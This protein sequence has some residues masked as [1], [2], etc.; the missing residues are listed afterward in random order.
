MTVGTISWLRADAEKAKRTARRAVIA[1]AWWELHKPDWAPALPVSGDEIWKLQEDDLLRIVFVGDYASSLC[2]ADWDF[3]IHP[4]FHD[5]CCNAVAWRPDFL[6]LVRELKL[7][8]K[9]LPGFNPR[10]KCWEPPETAAGRVDTLRRG[11][12]RKESGNASGKPCPHAM[13]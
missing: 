2:Y 1:R 8:P 5:W 12:I 6:P 9:K 10:I 7:R 13:P 4:S 3:R 11:R